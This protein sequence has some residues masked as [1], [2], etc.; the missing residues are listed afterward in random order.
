MW[1]A[2]HKWTRAAID[3]ERDEFFETRVT[4]HPDIWTAL[5]SAT[6]WLQRGQR[7][8]RDMAQGIL[9][10]AA[11]TVPTGDLVNGA[12]DSLGN[13]YHMPEVVISDPQNIILEVGDPI[14]D[15]PRLEGAPCGLDDEEEEVEKRRE[16]KGKGV[17][18]KE[19][20]IRVRARL[21]DRGNMDVVIQLDKEQRVKSLVRKIKDEAAVGAQIDDVYRCSCWKQITKA[22]KIAYLGRILSE[23]DTLQA[24]GWQEGHVI[25]VLVLR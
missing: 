14:K 8:D 13:F 21:S 1:T 24:Q 12:Y 19:N 6:E 5:R 9:D 2:K 16:E 25:N 15:V 7:A 23:G 3:H 18:K 20:M 17:F 11:I 22:V 10:A 4:G